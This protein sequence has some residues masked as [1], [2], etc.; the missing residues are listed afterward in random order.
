MDVVIVFSKCDM[1]G[2]GSLLCIKNLKR[3]NTPK[4]CLSFGVSMSEAQIKLCPL[5]PFPT[6]CTLFNNERFFNIS[7][8]DQ[9]LP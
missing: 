5:T 8:E 9:H 4:I 7:E 1:T 2:V 6:N 3:L